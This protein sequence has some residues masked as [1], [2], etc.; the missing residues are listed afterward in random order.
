MSFRVV[1]WRW[2][3]V[4]PKVPKYEKSG[5]L[6]T[7]SLKYVRDVDEYQRQIVEQASDAEKAKLL[8]Q[9]IQGNKTLLY[10]LA[11]FHSALSNIGID[12]S[13]E[14]STRPLWKYRW[15]YV[16]RLARLSNTFW[17]QCQL[18]DL[19]QH[20]HR[21]GTR[22]DRIGVL[23]PINFDPEVYNALQT[24]QYEGTD[25]RDVQMIGGRTFK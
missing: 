8:L 4:A 24:G 12:R 7:K 10:M 1:G 3:S 11:N 16:T 25:F 2:Y 15:H 20:D 6:L 19:A 18:E 22:P 13:A 23:D 21:L 9:K 17:S 14:P 5:L